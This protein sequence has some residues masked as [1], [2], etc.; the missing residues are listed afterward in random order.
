MLTLD[1]LVVVAA[2]LHE[3]AEF[4]QDV[5]GV[6]PGAGGKH[7]VFGTHNLLLGLGAGGYLEVIAIDPEA[8]AQLRPRWFGLDRF[9]GVPQLTHWVCESDALA[10][11]MAQ[12]FGAGAVP[13]ELHR[14]GLRWQMGLPSAIDLPFDGVFPAMIS[15]HGAKAAARLVPCGCS[16][17]ALVVSHPEAGALSAALSPLLQDPLVEIAPAE[18]PGLA[19]TF[20]TPK[21]EVTLS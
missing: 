9:C 17:S 20:L 6:T 18:R 3:G 4:V 1:H 14:G 7:P 2:S 13:L 15:W 21:G 12:A 16:L 8:E 19:A 11:D 10:A 5:L